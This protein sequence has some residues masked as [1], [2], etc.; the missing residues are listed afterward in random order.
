MTLLKI[1]IFYD[2]AKKKTPPTSRNARVTEMEIV[3]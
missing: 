1:K 3:T 2:V